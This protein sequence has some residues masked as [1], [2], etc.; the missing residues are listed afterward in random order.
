MG[1]SSN[2]AKLLRLR[3]IACN[4]IEPVINDIENI[5]N[6]ESDLKDVKTSLARTYKEYTLVADQEKLTQFGLTTAQIGMELNPMKQREVL[7]K[8]TDGNNTIDVYI[9][10]EETEHKTIDEFTKRNCSVTFWYGSSD[11]RIC[12]SKRRNK[13]RYS[14]S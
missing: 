12:R 10:E 11:F 5:L 1:G 2:A 7:T 4:D 14:F 13:F 9:D 8:I 6:D 3:R